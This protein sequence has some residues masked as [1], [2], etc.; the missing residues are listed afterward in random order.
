MSKKRLFKIGLIKDLE[1]TRLSFDIDVNIK[2]EKSTSYVICYVV[3]IRK[4]KK[5]NT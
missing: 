4:E 1:Y 3:V 5:M 2:L